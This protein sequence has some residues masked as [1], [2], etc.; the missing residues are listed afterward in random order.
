MS[1][2]KFNLHMLPVC[3]T[4]FNN[5]Y[6]HTFNFSAIIQSIL[7]IMNFWMI[8]LLLAN[9]FE[10]VNWLIPQVE[11]KSWCGCSCNC[12][13]FGNRYVQNGAKACSFDSIGIAHGCSSDVVIKRPQRGRTSFFL[14]HPSI[15][16]LDYSGYGNLIK[17]SHQKWWLFRWIPFVRDPL[18]TTEASG[19]GI[20]H[21]S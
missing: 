12:N 3:R 1:C 6:V 19:G 18:S 16:P 8:T 15:R 9:A 14:P 10:I 5:R 11:M 20:N 21:R 7:N 17:K 13:W 4:R 2:M